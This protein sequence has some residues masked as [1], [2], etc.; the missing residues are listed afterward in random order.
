MTQSDDS[1]LP[2]REEQAEPP[3]EHTSSGKKSEQKRNHIQELFAD[4]FDR[5]EQP[6]AE[7]VYE[8]SKRAPKIFH[9]EIRL[10]DG[11]GRMPPYHHLEDASL[12]LAGKKLELIFRHYKVRISGKHLNG[13]RR[14]LRMHECDFIQE[15]NPNV[16]N[17]PAPGKPIIEKI[18]F[19]KN[20]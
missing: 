13:I 3:A 20:N 14:A 8:A 4:V 5:M 7:E 18:E 15:F 9:L 6:D 10:A 16:W 17:W 19:L 2:N 1:V 12:D 11:T